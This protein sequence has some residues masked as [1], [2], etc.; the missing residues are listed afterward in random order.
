MSSPPQRLFDIFKAFTKEFL[1]STP[2]YATPTWTHRPLK[3]VLVTDF[4]GATVP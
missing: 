3:N 1:L 2:A 4:F